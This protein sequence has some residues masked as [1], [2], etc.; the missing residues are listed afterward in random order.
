MRSILYYPKINIE[1]NIW[2]RNAILYWD[3]VCSIVPS[4]DYLF[5]PSPEI[6]YLTDQDFYRPVDPLRLFQSPE[7][8]NFER[9]MLARL[10]HLKG[11]LRYVDTPEEPTPRHGE[12]ISWPRLYESIHYNKI[13]ALLYRYMQTHGLLH[14]N[15][16]HIWLE[17]DK[18]AATLYMSVLAKYLARIDEQ[19][20]V[21]GTD[22]KAY[23]NHSYAPAWPNY[24]TWC[25]DLKI[26]E[27]L[28]TPCLDV[29][30]EDVIAFRNQRHD[31]LLRFR[32][33]ID[34]FES[35]LKFCADATEIKMEAVRFQERLELA[36]HDIE[37][38]LK[39]SHQ[40]N[41]RTSLKT[42]VEGAAVTGLLTALNDPTEMNIITAAIFCL[43]TI[44]LGISKRN[45]GKIQNDNL[46]AAG[47]SYL[48]YANK[49]GIL[50]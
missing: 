25:F 21:I 36:T 48:Y 19:A 24:G 41:R 8:A 12:K 38:L 17:M 13:S 47:F 3:E 44:I 4:T 10:K 11:K 28:P 50:R 39:E 22:Q 35:K 40:N 45:L 16:D 20:M 29:P 31:E 27:C 49:A 33:V 6:A 15:D 1:D 42:F 26:Q 32:G 37:R 46:S 23:M 7:A 30:L 2:L 5:H 9:E 43:G 14:W 34:E 18:Q